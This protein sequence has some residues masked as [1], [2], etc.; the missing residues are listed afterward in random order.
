MRSLFDG[1]GHIFHIISHPRC[2]DNGCSIAEQC[3]HDVKKT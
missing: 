1:S 2:A 3:D